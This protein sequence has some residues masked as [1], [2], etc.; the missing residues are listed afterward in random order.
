MITI[1]DSTVIIKCFQ[2]GS[3]IPVAKIVVPD[4]LFNEYLV[5]EERH[6]KKVSQVQK[7]TELEDY[8]E[9]YYLQRYAVFLNE[10][11]GVSFTKMSGFGDVSVL[12]LTASVVEKFG[13]GTDQLSLELGDESGPAVCVVTDDVNLA[14]KIKSIYDDKQV[15]C[16]TLEDYSH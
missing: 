1:A 3:D 16:C 9:A 2:Q 8:S 13:R 5:A 6:Q 14:K 12:A 11:S 10:Y 7:A 15:I 4:D